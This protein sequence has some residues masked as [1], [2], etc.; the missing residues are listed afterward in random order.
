MTKKAMN[1]KTSKKVSERS[2]DQ[3]KTEEPKASK[4]DLGESRP[5][6]GEDC[7]LYTEHEN[8]V[9]DHLLREAVRAHATW[10]DSGV[11]LRSQCDVMAAS[12]TEMAGQLRQS[13]NSL[14][15]TPG[16]VSFLMSHSSGLVAL[17][18][19]FVDRCDATA[20]HFARTIEAHASYQSRARQR[21]SDLSQKVRTM[22]AE[23]GLDETV[24]VVAELVRE[25]LR[26]DPWFRRALYLVIYELE[27]TDREVVRSLMAIWGDVSGLKDL[28]NK[29][30]GKSSTCG[31]A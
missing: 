27:R 24:K 4:K 13:R 21:L 18:Q 25:C 14:E 8:V 23:R 19:D 2:P 31:K 5:E 3:E 12:A 9:L 29:K 7:V 6:A 30:Y 28:L 22:R 15:Q 20:Q 17:P 1:K 26:E 10:Y 11:L 16:D